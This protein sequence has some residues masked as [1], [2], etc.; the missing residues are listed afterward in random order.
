[1]NDDTNKQT[2]AS[3]DDARFDRLVDGELAP[4][5]YRALLA[6]LDEEPGGWRRCALAFLESQALARELGGVRRTL[7]LNAQSDGPPTA[8]VTSGSHSRPRPRMG[9]F[10]LRTLAAMAA[11]FLVAFALGAGLPRWRPAAEAE[12]PTIAATGPIKQATSG[13]NPRHATYKPV[14]NVQLVVDGPAGDS[15]AVGELPVYELPGSMEDWLANE[16]P[17]LPSEVLQ[18]L[19]ERGHRVQRQVQYLPVQ[20]EDGRQGI[21]PVEGYQIT[22]VGQRVY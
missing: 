5:E 18:S 2:I 9:P 7:D 1:M 6:S 10:E 3:G 22:P 4:Q 20:L 12:R 16:R 13:V 15:T 11:S 8:F 19:T 17:A 21:V 14:G